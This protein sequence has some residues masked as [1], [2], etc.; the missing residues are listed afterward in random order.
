MKFLAS[1]AVLVALALTATAQSC[2][3]PASLAP[4]NTGTFQQDLVRARPQGDQRELTSDAQAFVKFGP[5]VFRNM[6][7]AKAVAKRQGKEVVCWVSERANPLAIFN[8]PTVRAVSQSLDATTIQVA[9]GTNPT[10]DRTDKDGKRLG[11]RVEFS[12]SSYDKTAETAYIPVGNL[13][14]SDDKKILA[15]ARGGSNLK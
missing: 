5:K 13:K 10:R 15:F 3:A 2:D 6:D 11:A 9:M 8:D 4:S 12:S 14:R 7:E 1:A